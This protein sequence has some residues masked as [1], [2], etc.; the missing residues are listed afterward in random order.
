VHPSNAADLLAAFNASTTTVGA[1]GAMSSAPNGSRGATLQRLVASNGV[2]AES[3]S[4]HG[5]GHAWAGGS[6]RGS[7]TDPR[8]PDA[9]AEML[10][11][12]LAH[13]RRD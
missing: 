3:W 10:R 7:Y 9:T 5:A 12:F 13:P 11:F 4:I 2:E 8:G 1:P 6:P